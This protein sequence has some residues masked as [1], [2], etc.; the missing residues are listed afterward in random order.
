MKDLG[1]TIGVFV[2]VTNCTDQQ[3]YT[4]MAKIFKGLCQAG[5]WGCF[6]EF[7]RIELPV[8]SVVAQQVL[9]ITNAKRS[10]SQQFT[11]PGDTQEISFNS[12]VGYFI[13][14]NPGYQGRQELPENLKSLFR[15]VAMMVPQREV[16][17]KVKLCSVGYQR[18]P[19][20][21]RK[22][23]ALYNLCEQ[24]LSKQKHYDFGLR[25]ILSVLRAAG[26]IKRSQIN[27]PEESL[28]MC[29]LRDM[30]LSKLVAQDVPLFLSLVSDL[31]PGIAS[32]RSAS[33]TDFTR[34]LEAV[35]EEEQLVLHPA[36]RTKVIQM[37]ETTSVRH[38][39][40]MVGPSGSGKS[41]II[42]CLQETLSRTTGIAHKRSKLFPKAI[43]SE[44]MFGETDKLSGEWVDGIFAVMWAK[45]N[46]RARRDIHWIICDGP[47]D[48]L[49]IENLNTVLDDNKILTLANGDRIPMSDN[50][51]LVFEVE[52]L[53]N[54]SPATVSRAGIIFVSESDLDWEPVLKSWIRLKPVNYGSLFAECFKKYVGV[55]EGPASYGHL[56]HFIARSCKPVVQCP[57]VGVIK[58][59][60]DLLDAL[61]ESSDLSNNP[62]ILSVELERIF[63]YSVA[64]SVGGILEHDDRIKFTAYLL[65]I[66]D[67]S[68]AFPT[69]AVG[70][71]I[72]EHKINSFSMDWEKWVAPA[73]DYPTGPMD[74]DFSNLFVPTMASTRAAYI[75]EHLHKR[76]RSTLLTGDSGT[77]KTSTALMF[78]NELLQRD[79]EATKIKKFSFSSATTLLIFQSSLDAE[80][81]KRGGKSFGPPGGKRMTIFLDDLHMPEKN[82]WGDAPTL[83]LV[84]Q[85]LETN[86]ICFLDKDKRGDLKSIEDVDYVA[87][88]GHPLGGRNDIPNRLKR[89]FFIINL[90]PPSS[91]S[92]NDIYGQMLRGKFSHMGSSIKGILHGLP[93][94]TVHLW[95]AMR[96]KMLPSPSK[97][98]YLFNLRDL[99]RV[100]QGVLHT[101]RNSLTSPS[102]LMHLWRHECIRVFSDKFTNLVDSA[103]FMEY[104]NNETREL[105]ELMQEQMESFADESKGKGSPMKRKSVSKDKSIKG[106]MKFEEFSSESFFIDFLKDEEVDEEGVLSEAPKLY[107]MGTS[108]HMIRERCMLYLT[109]YNDAHPSRVMNLVLFDDALRHLMRISRCLGMTRGNILLVGVGGSGKQSLTRLASYCAGQTLFQIT[110]SKSY[111]MNNLMDDLRAMYKACGKSGTKMTFL[112]T[113]AEIK[114]ESFMEVINSILTTGEIANLFPKDELIQMAS[115]IRNIA[116]KQVPNFVDTPDNLIKFFMS[117]AISNLHV[118]LCMSPVNVKFPERA[119]RFPGIIAGCTIDWFLPWPKE[120]LIAV[121]NGFISEMKIDCSEQVREDLVIH[122]GTVHQIVMDS[123]EEY[124]Q[125]MRRHVYQTPKSFLSFLADYSGM[126]SAKISEII[127]KANRVEIGLDKLKAGANDVEKMKVVLGGEDAKLRVAEAATNEMLKRL[128][129]SA[130]AAKKEENAVSKIKYDC[131]EVAARIT[132]EKADAEED[133]AKAQ[134]FVDEADAA[135]G[136][137]KPSDLSELKKLAKPSDIIRLIFDCVALLRMDKLVRVEP[138]EVTIG[139]GKDKRTS[140]FIKDSF[141]FAQTGM[142]SDARFLNSIFQF[143]R[144]EK[145]FINDETIEL[146][147]PYLNLEGFTAVAARNAS[148]AAEGLCTWCRAMV[149]YHEASKIVKPKLEALAVAVA[150]LEQAEGELFR[151]EMILKACQDTLANLQKDFDDQ[152]AMKYS[153]EANALSTKKRMELATSLIQGLSGERQR[154]KSDKEEFADTMRRLVGDVALACAFISYCGGFNQDFREYLINHRL[155]KDLKERKIPLSNSL[156]LTEFLADIGTI[157][158]WNLEGLPTDP[159]SIQNGIL[160][161]RS[162]RFPLLIDPQGQALRWICNH[163]EKRMP[164][165]G[166]SIKS[167]AR[168]REQLEFCLSEGKTFIVVGI[169]EE[170]DPM[171]NPVLEKQITIKGKTKYITISGKVCDYNDDFNMYLVTRLPNPHFSPED[172]SKCAIVDFTVTQKGLEDQL[173]GRVIQK[174]QRSL[175]ESLK[176]VLEEVTSNTKALIRL[177]QMLL[178]RLSENTGNLL[179]DEELINVLADTKQRSTDVKEKLVSAAEVRKSINLKREQY[180]PVATR[181]SVLYFAIV[182]M[183]NVN[184][185]YQTSLDQFQILFDSSMDVAEKSTQAP[186]RVNNI[187]DT[188]TYSA[189]RYINRGLYETDKMSFKLILAFKI[190]IAAEKLESRLVNLFLRGGGSI[191]INQARV[192]PIAWLP[193]EAWLNTLQIAQAIICFKDL[194]LDMEINENAYLSWYNNNEPEK[195]T[196]PVLSENRYAPDDEIVAAFNRLLIVRCLRPDRTILAVTDFIRAMETI[197]LPNGAPLP[198]MGPKYV[199]PVTDSVE[200][201]LKEME[202]TTP[203]IYLLSAGADP[204]DAVETLAHRKRKGIECVSMGEGQD[205]VAQRAIDSATLNGSWV[206]LQNC[207]LGLSFIDG[208]EATILRLRTPEANCHPDFRLFITTEPN[209]KFSIGLLQISSKVTNEP[210]K[211]L[212]AGLQR[213][214]TVMVDQDRVDRIESSVWRNLLFTLCFTHSTVQERRKFGPLGWSIPYEF[215]DGDLR[216]SIV[217]LEKHLEFAALSWSTLQFMVGEVQ[218]GGRITDDM[219]RRLFNG[220]MEA[221]MSPNTLQPSFGFSPDRPINKSSETFQ[222]K[223]HDYLDV[224]DYL[225]YIQGFPDI[226]SPEIFGMHPNADLTF[227]FKEANSLLNIILETQ[228]KQ[229]DGSAAGMTREDVVLAKCSSLMESLPAGFSDDEIDER[230]ASLGGFDQPL[231]VFLYQEA[232]RLQA[233]IIKVR[234]TLTLTAQAIRGETVVTAD[235]M[236]N[237]DAIFN[238]RVPPF[239]LYSA[240]GDELSWQAPNLGVWFGGLLARETQYRSWLGRGRPSAFWLTGFFNPQGFLTAVQQEITRSHKQENWALDSMTLHSEITEITTVEGVKAAPK[241]SLQSISCMY[242]WMYV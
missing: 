170:I 242:M 69:I 120:A 18:F 59:C 198:A 143:S 25:N 67:K 222:Y 71:T 91:Q 87:A 182:D 172:Q 233:T 190:L 36:W 61:L 220:Y 194:P 195:F 33:Q 219:D 166:V 134:P 24:Q 125:K 16:I 154:W 102:V 232:Q 52:D 199:T 214:Y 27:S 237:I 165:F 40:M 104:L 82:E 155:S 164:A 100:F 62:T 179:D 1:R 139:A 115:E 2:V 144:V 23:A 107:E 131:Q 174:E 9:T 159:L 118:V 109:R 44:M 54:A 177:D 138:M 63:L 86:N 196:V 58:G 17:I 173:L 50:V 184:C 241:V 223:I 95:T 12:Q 3:R 7:N 151:S 53:R 114:E 99:S 89:H 186:K 205:I 38:G 141:K 116:V 29:T 161:T 76:G 231:N 26:Q 178:E 78:F 5:L 156:D 132:K 84:R 20:L 236:R 46:D 149:Q 92:I 209:P 66:A 225:R 189:Y 74:P 228:P 160:V 135:A 168:F 6:D 217:F 48:A 55:C 203:V 213:A 207:H 73:W 169:E 43:T 88:M 121:S 15:G 39:I 98:H 106:D 80:L 65:K 32:D 4:D 175:E 28:L 19:E 206:L 234:T 110:V 112:V 126:Y 167:G 238:A 42:H 22:F 105:I 85:L 171:L 163:E 34:A 140:M 57:R 193:D 157:G 8:L 70:D 130:M 208:M 192:K 183:A 51:K 181:G 224:G 93:D 187:V 239:W 30:N 176:S 204:T 215:N 185:M 45:F 21:A 94:A 124:F 229:S 37:Y 108:L 226:D 79:P 60:C 191:D 188:M 221:W 41:R 197:V 111:S 147:M 150:R 202:A 77:S 101:P 128:E 103:V 13:T 31:F 11:F 162:S 96:S 153:I 136:S 210:P 133:L 216:A 14:M 113:E 212:R 180:R 230:I 145:D 119:R 211:G 81:D 122:M 35:V 148:K 68:E 146:M 117:R 123:C 90:L 129:V 72:F 97:F 83:E 142:L 227:R 75:L 200:S 235:V 201:V 152:I 10:N 137:I 218:Y 240:A 49:W 127:M 64:W 47:V 158:D 56:F